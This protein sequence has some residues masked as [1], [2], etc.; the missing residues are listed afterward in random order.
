MY[1]E[2]LF[3]GGIIFLALTAFGVIE[4]SKQHAKPEQT[5]ITSDEDF[6]S[7]APVVHT[8][9][10]ADVTESVKPST[11]AKRPGTAPSSGA[12]AKADPDVI[13]G[14]DSK[15]GAVSYQPQISSGQP[16]PALDQPT[17]SQP[18]PRRPRG[19]VQAQGQETG[20]EDFDGGPPDDGPPDGGPP[21]G[22]PPPSGPVGPG[23]PPPGEG[24]P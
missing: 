6:I 9:K 4:T 12:K 24:G 8:A 21:D 2:Y 17:T 1:K 7:E 14:T 20:G 10:P 19:R 3:G 18:T 11:S 22:G 5:V 16:A 13:V 15:Q 23:G